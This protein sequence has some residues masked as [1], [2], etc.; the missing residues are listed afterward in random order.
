MRF[1]RWRR[2]KGGGSVSNSARHSAFSSGIGMVFS[3]ATRAGIG[4]V[5]QVS[6]ASGLHVAHWAVEASRLP[7]APPREYMP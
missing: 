6:V 4:S 5:M 1:S 3:A 7:A 2:L